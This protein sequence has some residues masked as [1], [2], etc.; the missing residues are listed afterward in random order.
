MTIRTAQS[1]WCAPPLTAPMLSGCKKSPVTAKVMAREVRV[2]TLRY[3]SVLLSNELRGRTQTCRVGEVRPQ[4]SGI[5][6][7]RLFEEGVVVTKAHQLY[8]VNPETYAAKLGMGVEP[9]AAKNVDV[10]GP[11]ICGNI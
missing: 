6:I 2:V 1:L 5:V 10:T 4:V 11:A 3:V 7:K 9:V 8:Q